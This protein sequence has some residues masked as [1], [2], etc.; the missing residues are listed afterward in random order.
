MSRREDGRGLVS[1]PLSR[2]GAR[3]R[4]ENLGV[5]GM[6]CPSLRRVSGTPPSL[7]VT[8]NVLPLQKRGNGTHPPSTGV[9]GAGGRE[10]DREV[11]RT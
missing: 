10:V 2:V 6:C 8:V 5:R 1:T 7:V 4:E 3:R 11:R 9:S